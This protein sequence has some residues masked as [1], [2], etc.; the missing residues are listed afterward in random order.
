MVYAIGTSTSKS[1]DSA[2]PMDV[3]RQLESQF[4]MPGDSD[5]Y[6]SSFDDTQFMNILTNGI[7]QDS[8][9]LYSMPLPFRGEQTPSVRSEEHTSE[10]Q[11][12]MYLVCR[13]L[14]EK[15]KKLTIFISFTHKSN[16]TRLSL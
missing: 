7:H 11:S 4:D 5:L 10:L 1:E 16:F 13:L 15:K 8:D 12:P 6:V 14:L 9:G 3:V 2:V